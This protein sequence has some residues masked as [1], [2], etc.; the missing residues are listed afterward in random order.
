[1]A[2]RVILWGCGEDGRR[3]LETQAAFFKDEYT[4]TFVIDSQQS[5]WGHKYLGHW[6][7]PPTLLKQLSYDKILVSSLRYE[8]EIREKLAVQYCIPPEKIL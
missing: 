8:S 5:L 2:E 7:L 3:F 4:F 1:M 6:I